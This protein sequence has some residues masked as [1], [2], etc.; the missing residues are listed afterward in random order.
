MLRRADVPF[1]TSMLKALVG[2]DDT[3]VDASERRGGMRFGIRDRG[4]SGTGGTAFGALPRVTVGF[5]TLVARGSTDADGGAT[6]CVG[7]VEFSDSGARGI[8]NLP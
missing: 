7:G 4:L 8:T 1:S 2:S 3:L 6:E 5:V